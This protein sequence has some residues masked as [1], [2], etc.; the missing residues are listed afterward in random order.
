MVVDGIVLDETINVALNKPIESDQSTPSN[1]NDGDNSTKWIGSK[2]SM[3]LKQLTVIQSVDLDYE[4]GFN[5]IHLDYGIEPNTSHKDFT[6][7]GR[8]LAIKD[9]APNWEF[10]LMHPPQL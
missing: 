6:S 9:V 2:F 4:S 7:R 8:S 10:H 1:L 3:D 5:T